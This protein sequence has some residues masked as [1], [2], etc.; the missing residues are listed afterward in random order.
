MGVCHEKKTKK[1][2]VDD[3]T[4]KEEEK[5][6]ETNQETTKLK[7]GNNRL[8]HVGAEYKLNIIDSSNNEYKYTIR[9]EQILSRILRD[10][11]N[12]N[13]NSDFEIEFENF[14]KIKTDKKDI[15]F[16]DILRE[17]FDNN[18]PEIINMKY[19]KKGLDIPDNIIQA[20][21][22][23]NK[24]IGNAIIDNPETF[25]IITYEANSNKISSYKYK[26]SDYSILNTF[27]NFTA[28]CN[29]RNCLYF[30]GGEN[31]Q[32]NDLDKT[33]LKY[34][35]FLYIDLSTLTEDKL[36][37]NELPNLIEARTWHS[38]IFV[39]N[40]Y[41]F[42]IGGSNTRTV[43]LYDIDEK[44]L[45]KDSEL[46]EIRCESTLCLVN[47]TYL[48]AFFGFVLH[49]EYNKNIERCN[50]LKEKRKW[51][52][53]NYQVKEGINLKLS[54]FGVTYF[55]ENELL[56]IGGNDNDNDEKRFD[57]HYTIAQNED[58]KDIITEYDS[59]LK[60]NSIVFREKLFHPIA[61]NKAIN[62]PTI[63]GD[64][65]KI[66]IFESGKI[67]VMKNQEQN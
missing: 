40:K 27:N 28:Y 8:N 41:I 11:V 66:F 3:K 1:V 56:L 57:Y 23:N 25:G 51:E 45:T 31:E 12:F 32:S 21:I 16:G 6:D 7:S 35:D 20:Y 42:I 59:E 38:M 14:K 26:S 5:K 36:N 53:V 44:K 67:N 9:G 50:L 4:K 46:N 55:K 24:I 19:I 17:V 29:A 64:N 43:E 34:N 37:V 61:E 30:S 65:I 33:S 39:P 2:D 52:Y 60:E 22:E 18:I 48:Y 58:E 63:I 15:I 62:I 13:P 10:T 54:F 49:Q 47:N